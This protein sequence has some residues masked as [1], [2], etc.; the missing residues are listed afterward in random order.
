M[1]IPQYQVLVLKFSRF[2]R[3]QLTRY[4]QFPSVIRG[5]PVVTRASARNYTANTLS[6][7]MSQ[8]CV[9][10]TLLSKSIEGG[11]K[12]LYSVRENCCKPAAV[13]HDVTFPQDYCSILLMYLHFF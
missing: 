5:P 10:G 8:L 13:P 12:D 4:S 11:K 6:K 7:I 9:R 3:F 2:T 1:L